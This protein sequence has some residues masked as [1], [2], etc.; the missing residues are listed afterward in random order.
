MMKVQLFKSP[1]DPLVSLG[2]FTSIALFMY[3]RADHLQSQVAEYLNSWFTI[4][5]HS[6]FSAY[7]SVINP[8]HS[9]LIIYKEFRSFEISGSHSDIV[10][11]AR[12]IEL[13]QTPIY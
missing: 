1:G 13:S 6:R 9:Y 4:W 7:T 8:G 2:G 11:L 3:F 5:K 12:V 10:L